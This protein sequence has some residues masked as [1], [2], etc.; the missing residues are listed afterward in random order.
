MCTVDLRLDAQ[1]VSRQGPRKGLWERE[2]T[3]TLAEEDLKPRN[4]A[5]V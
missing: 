2:D 4:A 5:V 1:Q 3:L